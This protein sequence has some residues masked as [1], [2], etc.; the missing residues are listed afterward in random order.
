MFGTFYMPKNKLPDTY[1]I[2]DKTFPEGFGS[3]IV[4]PF[5]R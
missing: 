3:Q 4:Y 5:T 2:E 1:G